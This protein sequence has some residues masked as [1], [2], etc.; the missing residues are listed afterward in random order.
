MAWFEQVGQFVQQH[1][2][3]HPGRHRP[4]PVGQP[5]RPVGHRAG[6][7]TTAHVADP[8]H[9]QRLYPPVQVARGQFGRSAQQ[10]RVTGP[11][12]GPIGLSPGHQFDHLGHQPA[13]VRASDPSRHQHHDLVA[14]PIGRHG[15]APARAAPDLNLLSRIDH[16]PTLGP[17]TDI[18]CSPIRGCGPSCRVVDSSGVRCQLDDPGPRGR[19]W[20]SQPA[21]SGPGRPQVVNGRRGASSRGY[22]QLPPQVWTCS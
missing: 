9:A 10:A 11:D 22:P 18:P 7:P 21:R 5:D 8:A 1:V 15:A 3:D 4:Q 19:W 16:A 6:A 20:R 17:G 2:V 13:L 12:P 14:V